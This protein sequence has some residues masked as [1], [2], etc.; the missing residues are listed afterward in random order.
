MAF[1]QP[2]LGA[3]DAWLAIWIN[4]PFPVQALCGVSVFFLFLSKV[5]SIAFSSKGG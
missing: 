3:I 4:L 5:V 2:V 1:V